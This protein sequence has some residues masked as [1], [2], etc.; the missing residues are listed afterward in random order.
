[1]LK[2]FYNFDNSVR[3]KPVNR[4]NEEAK[5][6]AKIIKRPLYN[7]KS[8]LEWHYYQGEYYH[9]K[10]FYSLYPILNELIGPK[11]AN[12]LNL[13][14]ATNLPAILDYDSQLKLY[15]IFSK[16]FIKPHCE[17]LTMYD[18]GFNYKTKPHYKN[19]KK[20]K[21]YCPKEDYQN[22][23]NDL[24]KMTSLDYLMGQVDRVGC[25]FLFEKNKTNLSLAPLFDYAEAYGQPKKDCTFNQ[26]ENQNL[27]FSVGNAF[28]TMKIGER[29]YKRLLKKEPHFRGYLEIIK[30]VDIIKILE[31]IV[32]ETNLKVPD[33]Y[34]KYYEAKTKA[35]QKALIL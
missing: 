19:L 26:E 12:K 6:V 21:K 8:D 23:K 10:F 32:T 13:R 29:K 20:I 24:L 27:N 11:I 15:G 9:F 3:L 35:K 30:K 25:N 22:L 2:E 1:M 18:L 31:E 33:S 4:G 16:N 14:T 34:Y 17:Y 7:A 28:L 5:R